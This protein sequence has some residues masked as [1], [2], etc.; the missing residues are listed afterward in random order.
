MLKENMA[1]KLNSQMNM[2]FY[3]SNLYQQMSAWAEIN[4]YV[5]SSAFLN[6]Q[7]SEERFH[8]NRLYKYL[9]DSGVM[10]VFKTIEA[11]KSDFASLHEVFEKAMEHEIHLTE[12]INEMVSAA[13]N[14]R[15]YSSF[16]FLQWYVAEQHE[17]ETLFKAVLDKFKVIGTEGQGL[18]LIDKEIEAM[19]PAAPADTVQ[20]AP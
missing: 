9:L 16:Q 17:E 14:E 11:P 18:Y 20:D 1:K 4:G 2:E 6:N 7:S 19:I 15:D 3:S 12:V 5:G 10:P 13:Q 8:M